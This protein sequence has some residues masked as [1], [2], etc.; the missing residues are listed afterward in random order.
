MLAGNEAQQPKPKPVRRRHGRGQPAPELDTRVAE[1]RLR[2]SSTTEETEL[3]EKHL[4]LLRSVELVGPPKTVWLTVTAYLV[5]T[6]GCASS[7][8]ASAV[9]IDTL[10]GTTLAKVRCYRDETL[11][12]VRT[13]TLLAN[14]IVTHG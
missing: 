13:K 3:A 10:I 8:F 14:S 9:G 12:V 5:L 4:Q 6:M 1:M 7:R 2:Q 11:L